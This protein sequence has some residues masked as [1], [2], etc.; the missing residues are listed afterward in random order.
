MPTTYSELGLLIDRHRP[1]GDS[2]GLADLTRVFNMGVAPPKTGPNSITDV[3]VFGALFQFGAAG[4]G[5]VPIQVVTRNGSD[6]AEPVD[7]SLEKDGIFHVTLPNGEEY[8]ITKGL[9]IPYTYKSADGLRDIHS[10]I[11]VLFN[12][13]GQP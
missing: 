10:N 9:R 1:Y 4:L 5:L 8:R 12:G 11:L 3:D 13:D 2:A 6:V 7:T